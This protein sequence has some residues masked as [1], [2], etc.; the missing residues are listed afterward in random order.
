MPSHGAAKASLQ[1]T[2]KPHPKDEAETGTLGGAGTKGG[3]VKIHHVK[4]HGMHHLEVHPMGDGIHHLQIHLSEGG[5]A[6]HDIGMAEGSDKTEID[7]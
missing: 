1:S 2:V 4:V 3:G 7:T 6:D 5:K